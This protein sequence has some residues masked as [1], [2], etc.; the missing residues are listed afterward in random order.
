M[1]CSKSI[2]NASGW[3]KQ[4][5]A[6][7]AR[8][9]ITAGQQTWPVKVYPLSTKSFFCYYRNNWSFF[10]K[11]LEESVIDT[12]IALEIGRTTFKRMPHFLIDDNL[13]TILWSVYIQ[14]HWLI[15][16]CLIIIES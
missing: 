9:E 13:I 15:T 1:T 8:G 12:L 3:W 2:V 6:Y 14:L 16:S 5:D 7:G 11:P 10:F 4:N